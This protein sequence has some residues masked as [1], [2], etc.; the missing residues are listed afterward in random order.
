[1]N[2]IQ[3]AI[4]LVGSQEKLAKALGLEHYQNVQ[5]WLRTNSVPAKYCPEIERL[6][7][8]AIL[9]EELNPDIDWAYVR[10]SVGKP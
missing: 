5:H 7:N 9:C 3:K 8:R 10:Q 2:A 1:M 4:D 6:T